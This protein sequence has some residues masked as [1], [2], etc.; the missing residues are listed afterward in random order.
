MDAITPT[1]TA[2]QSYAWVIHNI[3]FNAASRLPFFSTGGWTIRNNKQ[4]QI[5]DYHL[6]YL[7]VYEVNEEMTPDGDPNHGEI[8]FCHTLR[9]GFSIII[10]NN[11]PVA[12][13]QKLDEAWW[14]LMNGI[15]RDQFVMNMLDTQAYGHPDTITDNPDNV[16]VESITRGVKRYNWGNPPLNNEL[17]IAELQ[18]EIWAFWRANYPPVITDDLDTIVV[19]TELGD[20][21]GSVIEPLSIYDFTSTHPPFDTTLTLT[22]SKNPSE[23]G[24]GIALTAWVAAVEPTAPVPTGTVSFRI[25]GVVQSAGPP[26]HTGSIM[27]PIS[28]LTVGDHTIVAEYTPDNADYNAS[29]SPTI[30]QTVT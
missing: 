9:I 17:P 28:S 24:E 8:R 13:K 4:F 18:Y 6:P 21:P 20:P 11:D 14:A 15:W 10:E 23:L 2:T 5:K 7:G 26:H 1:V 30:Q 19:T 29:V 25:D 16:R 22:S 27:F 3:F 12:T